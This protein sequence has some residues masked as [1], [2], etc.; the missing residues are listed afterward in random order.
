MQKAFQSTESDARKEWIGGYDPKLPSMIS[1]DE[2]ITSMPISSF[3][4][5]ELI[6]HG[7][8]N[9]D[10]C[11]PSMID[12]LKE[13]QRK[14]LYTVFT[15]KL[16]FKSASKKVAQ[17]AGK[18]ASL[19]NYHHGEVCLQEYFVKLSVNRPANRKQL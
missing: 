11:I 19:T 18:V 9:C 4:E 8:S 12:G 1:D 17:L 14:V 2:P 6:L 15:E 13:A 10:R 3:V 7:Y 5:R 16:H